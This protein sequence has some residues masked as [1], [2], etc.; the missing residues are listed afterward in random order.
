MVDLYV[1]PSIIQQFVLKPKWGLRAYYNTLLAIPG[2]DNY[3]TR[4]G[5]WIHDFLG[6]NNRQRFYKTVWFKYNGDDYILALE[7]TPDHINPLKELKTCSKNDPNLEKKI[8]A[9]SV[10]LWGYMI[11]T[12]CNYGYVSL[13]DRKDREI[14]MEVYIERN[15]KEF[16]NEV[17]RFY[18]A[19]LN[20]RWFKFDDMLE[21]EEDKCSEKA[22]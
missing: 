12:D 14:F 1:T 19:L 11:L 10:Q 5:R 6:F 17:R 3:F 21:V 18:D 9:A 13:A 8:Y 20:T 16:F 4:T 22:I 2:E 15:D 7:G